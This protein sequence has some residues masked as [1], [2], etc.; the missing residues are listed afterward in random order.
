MTQPVNTWRELA[1]SLADGLRGSGDL[2]DPAW[3]AAFA[4]TPRHVFVPRFLLTVGGPE[5]SAAVDPEP[6]LKAVYSD[7]ALT[8]EHRPHPAGWTT[9]D[10]AVLSLPTSSSTSPGLMARMVERL[11]VRTGHRVLEIGT[12]TGY[13][14]A[15]LCHRL[16]ADKVVSVDLNPD[17]ITTARNA[18]ATLGYT[19]VLVVGDGGDGVPDHGPYDRIIATA[20]V[21]A[22]PAAW[23]DQLAP[24][25]KIIAN[26]RGELAT[27][28]LCLLTKAGEKVSGRFLPMGGHFMWMRPEVDNPLRPHQVASAATATPTARSTTRLAPLPMV[29]DADF[30]FLLQLHIHGA[31][32][33]YRNEVMIDGGRQ[34]VVTLC[35][36]DGSRADVVAEST[37]A[38]THHVVQRGRRRLWDTV[39]T[40][41]R[42]FADSGRP[43]V[44]RFGVSV[45]SGEQFVWLDQ[46][47]GWLRWPLPA[48]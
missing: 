40:A 5:L 4:E 44:G 31:E 47:S 25:G 21:P 35:A 48:V 11:E 30:R 22:I 9:T 27:G 41:W 45:T 2:T 37:P 43:D 24:G 17:L 13:N 1:R 34:P 3:L 29:D 12:G 19:P 26:V 42:V 14:A 8:T 18:L 23:I 10:G 36:S 20:A 28:P 7:H 39:E 38:G 16:G 33:L 6:W 46:P 32:S 15:L